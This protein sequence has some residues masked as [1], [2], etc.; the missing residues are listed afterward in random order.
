MKIRANTA[1]I[2]KID[3]RPEFFRSLFD[4][5]IDGPGRADFDSLN[6]RVRAP[7]PGRWAAEG[8]PSSSYIVS[9]Y[10][11]Y[12]DDIQKNKFSRI[13]DVK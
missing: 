11:P 1:F 6:K 4:F 5:R 8:G 2:L 9:G 13:Q 12:L 3:G 7:H 10:Y